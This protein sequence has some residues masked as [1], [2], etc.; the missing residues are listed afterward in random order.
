MKATASLLMCAVTLLTVAPSKALA[1]TVG[2][3]AAVAAGREQN[4]GGAP[5]KPKHELRALFAEEVA[6]SKAGTLSAADRERL[7]KGWLEPQSTP[8]PNSG[9]SRRDAILVVV[10]VVAITAL[11]VV[12]AH[13]GVD[14]KPRCEDEPGTPDCIQ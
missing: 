6:R 13:N 7:E 3:P 10:V 1:Q 11:A 14:P 2:R 12:L 5:A 4:L 9:F 8:K